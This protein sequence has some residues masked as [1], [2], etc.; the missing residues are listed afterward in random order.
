MHEATSCGQLPQTSNLSTSQ[1]PKE[2]ISRSIFG[3]RRIIFRPHKAT[4]IVNV[5]FSVEGTTQLPSAWGQRGNNTKA[6]ITGRKSGYIQG[7]GPGAE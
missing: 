2:E 3:G 5:H 4:Q 7:W 6:Q 1:V